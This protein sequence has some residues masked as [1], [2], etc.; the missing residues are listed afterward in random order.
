MQ[1]N[2]KDRKLSQQDV[3]RMFYGFC[4]TTLRH[5]QID[6]IREQADRLAKEETMSDLT[7]TTIDQLCTAPAIH[8]DTLFSVN[9]KVI[10]VTDSLIAQALMTLDEQEQAII[11]LY[12]LA[13][14]SDARIALELKIP[15]STVQFRRKHLLT[16]LKAYMIE[17][18]RHADV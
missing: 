11:L 10:G 8:T 13:D 6:L 7:E 12:Y 18:Y 2:C 9:G 15:R 4:R 3:V 16:T 14:W 1:E 17:R 5:A